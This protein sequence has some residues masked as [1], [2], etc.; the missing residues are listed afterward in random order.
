M[1]LREDKDIYDNYIF[2]PGELHNVLAMLKVL[3]KFIESSGLERLFVE[4]GIYGEN[5]LKQILQGKHMKRG[6]EAHMVLYLGLSK[7][8]YDECFKNDDNVEGIDR[9]METMQKL[10]VVPF[11]NIMEY[12]NLNNE[13]VKEIEQQNILSKLQQFRNEL[14]NQARF[15]NNYM[16]I[17]ELILLFT[18]AS[19]QNDWNLH[20][21]FFCT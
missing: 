18:R 13:L 5:T 1:Q 2:R 20:L 8:C 9:I 12:Q 7:M 6:I 17:F 15:Y 16:S 21:A 3:G 19:R 14:I 10:A 11:E 4:A